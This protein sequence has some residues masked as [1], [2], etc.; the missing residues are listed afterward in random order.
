MNPSIVCT[1]LSVCVLSCLTRTNGYSPILSCW[2]QGVALSA[3]DSQCDSD[4]GT[5]TKLGHHTGKIDYFVR[6]KNMKCF[7]LYMCTCLCLRK[8]NIGRTPVWS[9]CQSKINKDLST[10]RYCL[11]LFC[12][13]YA[14]LSCCGNYVYDNVSAC[15]ASYLLATIQHCTCCASVSMC[16][17]SLSCLSIQSS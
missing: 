16:V 3:Q 1:F 13:P 6:T 2:I 4:L 15:L 9:K 7:P 17:C 5:A 8:N 10:C 12:I 11:L 14:K